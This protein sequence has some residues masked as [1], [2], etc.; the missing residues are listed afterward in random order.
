MQAHLEQLK[1]VIYPRNVVLIYSKGR[2]YGFLFAPEDGAIASVNV[3][4]EENIN[5][6]QVVGVLNAGLDMNILLGIP[7]LLS[8]L[9]QNM[10]S[11]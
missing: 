9:Q 3:E 5:P 11:M 6:G 2:Y 1:Q 7:E 4:L 10:K 8:G